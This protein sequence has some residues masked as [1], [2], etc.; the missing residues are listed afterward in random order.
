MVH[1]NDDNNNSNNNHSNDHYTH[2]MRAQSYSSRLGLQNC[3]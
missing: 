2:N 1:N 3:H